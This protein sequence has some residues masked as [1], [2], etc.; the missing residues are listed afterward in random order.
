M[1]SR[2]NDEI[3]N[4]ETAD[5]SNSSLPGYSGSPVMDAEGCCV[6]IAVGGDERND[7]DNVMLPFDAD[8]IMWIN[9]QK[10]F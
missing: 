4:Q 6:G 1:S 10:N 8:L 2:W 3:Q 7:K 5:I 9:G